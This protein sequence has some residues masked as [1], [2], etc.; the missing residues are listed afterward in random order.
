MAGR[1]ANPSQAGG[2]KEPGMNVESILVTVEIPKGSRNKY[3]FDET[4]GRFKL[5]RML[6]SSVHY[7]ADYGFI[8]EALGED[9]D[10]LD[11]MVLVGEPTFT[12]CLI[13]SKPVGLFKMWDEKGLDHKVLCVPVNDPQWNWVGRI[14][15]VPEHLLDEIEHFFSIYKDLEM[16][17][18]RVRGWAGAEAAWE[19]IRKA[20]EAHEHALATRRGT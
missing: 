4:T 11:A 8:E 1:Q 2:R 19:V 12:G 6:F 15:D 9:G 14:E 10:P 5:D 17:K 18:T 3:E 13:A 7:P 20:R 16:K